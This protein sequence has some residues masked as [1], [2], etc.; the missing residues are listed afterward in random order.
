MDLA[1][2]MILNPSKS[3]NIHIL[4]VQ[5]RMFFFRLKDCFH[6]KRWMSRR[7]VEKEF[8]IGKAWLLR[9]MYVSLCHAILIYLTSMNVN[10]C[11]LIILNAKFTWYNFYLRCKLFTFLMTID[12]KPPEFLITTKIGNQS[13]TG[14]TRLYVNVSHS[15]C[16]FSNHRQ[17]ITD[18]ISSALRRKDT[19]WLR[20]KSNSSWE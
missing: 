9:Y 13:A 3:L 19:S 16:F 4:S 5:F 6:D 2:K 11:L 20:R 14:Y 10:L 1:H 7:N 8:K 15:W 17:L 18:V 12:W